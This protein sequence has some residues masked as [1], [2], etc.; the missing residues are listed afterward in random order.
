MRPNTVINIFPSPKFGVQFGHIP[1]HLIDFIEFLD[2]SAV[3]A[4]DAAI[5]FGTAWWQDEEPDA[6]FLTGALES[7]LE[8]GA[9][10]H[11]QRLYAERHSG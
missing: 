2:M 4:L 6:P 5:E 3:G 1:W 7:G 8:L 9:T 11:L 10:V